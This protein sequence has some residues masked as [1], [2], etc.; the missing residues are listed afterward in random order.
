MRRASS[1]DA[2]PPRE[3][4][5]GPG[6][7]T[8]PP[9]P[10]GARNLVVVVLDSLRHDTCVEARPRTLTRLGEVEQRYSY[11]SWTAPSHHNLLMGLLPHTNPPRTLAAAY[12]RE[13]YERHAQRLGIDRL[14]LAD[15]APELHLPSLLRNTLGY[16]TNAYVSMP[17]LN[18][19]TIL[20]RDFDRYELMPHHHDLAGMVERLRFA[21]DRP[22]FHLLNVGE[23]HYPY[24]SAGDDGHDLPR[25]S[26]LHGAAKQI[27]GVPVDDTFPFT[28][29]ELRELRQRQVRA[30]Q[31]VD[32]LLEGL[33]DAVPPNTWVVVTADHGELFGEDGFFGHGPVVHEKVFEVPFVEG[34]RG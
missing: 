18:P 29:G 32:A 11:A 33:L 27:G 17:V 25:L 31:H 14:D 5:H 19:R 12:Y 2:V 13:G 20:N 3:R 10:D 28:D 4:P 6:P 8:R 23:T 30:A 15:L 26:G 22:S 34:L 7:D 9:P 24:V 16:V 1:F 21:D